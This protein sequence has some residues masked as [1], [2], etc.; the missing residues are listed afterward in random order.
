MLVP[1]WMKEKSFHGPDIISKEKYASG[2]KKYKVTFQTRKTKEQ[3]LKS[4]FINLHYSFNTPNLNK[5]YLKSLLLKLLSK[6]KKELNNLSG[7]LDD[8]SH[9][10][11]SYNSDSHISKSNDCILVILRVRTLEMNHQC[12]L[13]RQHFVGF[14]LRFA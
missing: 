10:S 14:F 1:V 3:I 12:C 9:N 13:I 11:N 6:V 8:R 4:N 7:S 2:K 5:F